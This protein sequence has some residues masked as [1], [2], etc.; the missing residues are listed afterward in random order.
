MTIL[1][2]GPDAMI[3]KGLDGANWGL[4]AYRQRGGYRAIRKIVDEKLTP[5][6]V[7]AEVKNS[8]LRGRAGAGLALP[9]PR[10]R[11]PP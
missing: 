9:H 3:M 10:L 6:A 1:D 11:R 4:E 7:I 5:D 2:Y 8:A